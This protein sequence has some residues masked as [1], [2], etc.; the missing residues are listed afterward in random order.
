MAHPARG[1]SVLLAL[2]PSTLFAVLAVFAAA[3]ALAQDAD[4]VPPEVEAEAEAIQERGEIA[5]EELGDGEGLGADH[6]GDDHG[7][8]GGHHGELPPLWLVAPFVVLLLMI[9]T[10]P[11]F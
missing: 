5:D 8:E 7:G 6:G 1:L 9:A 4:L 10:G 2:I 11:L 3:P